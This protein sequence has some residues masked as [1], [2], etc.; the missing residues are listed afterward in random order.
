MGIMEHFGE[1]VKD[2]RNKQGWTQAKLASEI[3]VSTQ[4]ISAYENSTGVEKGKTPT[5]DRAALLAEKLGVSLD[6]LCGIE[7]KTAETELNNFADAI[8]FINKMAQHLPCSVSTKEIPLPPEECVPIG[9]D[10]NGGIVYESNELAAVLTI[11]SFYLAK[12]FRKMQ[13]MRALLAD[14]TID[15]DLYSSW[16]HGEME[17]MKN[18]SIDPSTT[19]HV[20]FM[21]E[22]GDC[23][24]YQPEEEG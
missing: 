22:D 23:L 5:L 14:K 19:G 12:Y 24:D 21:T 9:T 8:L 18:I 1:R 16:Y 10:C 6:Y 4:T 3:G 15:T 11:R 13:K 17:N 2:A 7:V 20:I